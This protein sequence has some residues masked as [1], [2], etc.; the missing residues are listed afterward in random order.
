MDKIKFSKR[1]NYRVYPESLK[2]E[3]VKEYLCSDCSKEYLVRKYGLGSRNTVTRWLKKHGD[4]N[5]LC[6]LEQKVKLSETMPE[7]TKDPQD[8][9]KKIRQLER[10]LE[11][12]KLLAEAYSR[13]IDIAEEEYKIPIRKKSDTKQSGK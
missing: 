11:D 1:T 6:I 2:Q 5:D 10:E 4:N 3:V 9:E 13:M 8:L 12:T 7:E